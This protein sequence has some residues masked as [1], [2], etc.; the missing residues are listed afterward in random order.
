MPFKIMKNCESGGF[1]KNKTKVACIV[2]ADESARMRVGN[3]TPSLHEDH[4]AGKG[5]NSL[6][7]NGSHCSFTIWI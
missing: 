2:E 1:D 7:H 3:S 4:I 6:Q 5:E